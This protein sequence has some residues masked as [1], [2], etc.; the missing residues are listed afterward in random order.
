MVKI[1]FCKTLQGIYAFD[2]LYDYFFTIF[3]HALRLIVAIARYS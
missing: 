2:Y 3:A 1:F